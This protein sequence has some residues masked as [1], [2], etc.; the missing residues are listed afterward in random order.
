MS[1]GGLVSAP[2]TPT[3]CLM[4]RYAGDFFSLSFIYL[5]NF[6]LRVREVRVSYH[7]N[8]RV[9]DIFQFGSM[10]QCFYGMLLY[11]MEFAIPCTFSFFIHRGRKE[12]HE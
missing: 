12:Q 2:D 3:L 8:L 6:Y 10:W 9:I 5:P 11:R 4:F 7:M 1:T